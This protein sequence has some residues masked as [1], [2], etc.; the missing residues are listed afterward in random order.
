MNNDC[1]HSQGELDV[2]LAFEM[3]E[4]ESNEIIGDGL[5]YTDTWLLGDGQLDTYKKLVLC[6]HPIFLNTAIRWQKKV[7]TELIDFHIKSARLSPVPRFN[8]EN[9]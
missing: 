3:Q 5:F 2:D 4:F 7:T 8:A 9:N 1:H 6:E